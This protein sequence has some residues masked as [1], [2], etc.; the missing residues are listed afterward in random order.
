MVER[1]SRSLPRNEK[2]EAA[3]LQAIAGKELAYTARVGGKMAVFAYGSVQKSVDKL[4]DFALR[5]GKVKKGAEAFRL[6]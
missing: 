5:V 3:I 1:T 2:H 4:F 6:D